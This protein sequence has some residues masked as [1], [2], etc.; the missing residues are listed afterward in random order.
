MPLT[1]VGL[2]KRKERDF[3]PPAPP[4]ARTDR[5][6]SQPST[7]LRKTFETLYNLSDDDSEKGAGQE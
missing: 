4:P 2:G 1:F 5:D 6:Q 3:T 7:A